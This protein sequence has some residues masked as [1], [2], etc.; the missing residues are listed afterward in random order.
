M[1]SRLNISVPATLTVLGGTASLSSLESGPG[2]TVSGA[3]VA[4]TIAVTIVAGDTAASIGVGSAGGASVTSH[5]NTLSLTGTQAQ[6]NLALASLLLTEPANAGSDVLSLSATDTAALAA[7]SGFAVDVVPATGPA[8]VAPPHSV[9]LQPDA[10]SP[11]SGM[12]LA[13][14]IAA[15]LAGM[16]LGGEETLSLTLSVAEGVLLLPGLSAMNGV[17]A[18][19]LGTGTILLSCTAAE[20]NE[21]NALLAG[22]EF[23]GPAGG[24]LLNYALWNASGVLPRV[25]T[26]GY[27]FLDVTGTAAA[28]GVFATGADTLITGGTGIAGTLAVNAT[29]SVLGNFSGGAVNIA[30]GAALEVP[31]DS[32]TLTGSSADFGSLA[33]PALTLSGTLQVYGTASFAGSVTLQPGARLGFSDGLTVYGTATSNYDVGVS[34]GSGAVLQGNGT[35]MVGNFSQGGVI[36]GGTLLALGGDT[37][38]IDAG[39]ITSDALLQVAGGGVMVLGPVGPLYGIFDTIALTIDTGV[40]LSFLQPGAQGVTGGYA[41]T[42]G[43]MGGAFVISDPEFF[44]GTVTNFGV[45]DALIFPD[46]L[47]ISVY[48]VGNNSFHIAGLDRTG[49]TDTYTVYASIAAGLTPAVGQDA[50]GDWE[51][52]M[53]P[54]EAVVTQGAPIV[55]TPGLAQPLLGVAIELAGSNTQSLILTLTAQHGSLSSNGG[56]AAASITLTAANVA[57][58]NSEVDAVSYFSS[59]TA[60]QVWFTSNNGLLSGVQGDILI[61]PGSAGTVAGYSGLGV[62]GAEMVSFGLAGGVPQIVQAMAAGAALVDGTVEFENILDARGMSGTGL[63]VDGGGEAIFDAAATVSLGSDVTLGDAGGAGTLMLLTDDFSL[64]GNATLASVAA[65]VGSVLDILG[66]MSAS[67]TLNIDAGGDVQV[68]GTGQAGFGVIDNS[69]GMA[70]SGTAVVSAASYQGAGALD[71][72]GTATLAVAGEIF[73]GG[74]VTVQPVSIGSGAVVRAA[75]FNAADGTLYDAGLV[76]AAVSMDIGDAVL[77]G[78]TLEAPALSADDFLTG[79]GVIDAPSIHIFNKIEAEGGRLLLNGNVTNGSVLGIGTGAILE[80]AGTMNPGSAPVYFEGTD[81]EL[82]LDDAGAAQFS[83]FQMTL[84]DAIDLVGIAPGR[85]TIAN[86]QAGYILDSLGNTISAFGLEQ[87]GTAQGNISIVSDGNGGSLLTVNGV[88]PCFARGTGILSPNGYRKVEELRPNDPVITANG[89]RRPV[90]WIGWR[91]LDLGPVAARDARPVLIMPDAFGPGRPLKALRLSPSHC[92][93]MGGVLI[94]VTHLVNGATVLRERVQA[95]TYFHIELDRHDIL[96]AEGLACESYFDDGNRA[97]LYREMGRRCPA[98][99]MYA[100][101]VTGGAKVTAVRHALHKQ[102]LAAGYMARHQLSLRAMAEGQSAMAEISEA[103]QGQVARF[104]FPRPVRELVLLSTTATP[105]DTDP[106][107][108]DRREL[109]VCLGAMRGVELRAGW[110]ARAVG[111]AGTWMGARAEL[112]FT[113]ARREISLPLAAVAQSWGR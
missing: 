100:P 113:R 12:L 60:D 103:A 43:G 59:G 96:L 6:V 63:I 58:L 73:L 81:A 66:R 44:T 14:P 42:L 92:I 54:S 4:D 64:T 61:T 93:Y 76:S 23:A 99:R 56:A 20:I 51:V 46:L 10:L 7:S 107:S 55:A 106:E 52:Y 72:G 8:F 79:Y 48:D 39:W 49:S 15:G 77:A 109:G 34:M 98:R 62:S 82:V 47:S 84:T 16:G 28:G 67:G 2:I 21:L 35:L 75:T 26:Y 36:D 111:D 65:A 38:E 102:A 57:A 86:N 91:T 27:V 94:P 78:G 25:V 13:D 108:D 97:V 90:R 24:Q 41:S 89:E 53:R 40:T 29:D 74:A 88:L 71:I 110:Q 105:A 1:S 104:V 32:M 3:G 101:V 33:S 50:Q 11:L 30:P 18:T 22:L 83:V 112:G 95:A 9:T 80:V 70:L 45:G 17:A 31:D 85:V 37:L 5:L 69:G 87:E 19:G 68:L